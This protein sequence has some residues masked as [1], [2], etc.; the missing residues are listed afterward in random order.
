MIDI[1]LP[2]TSLAAVINGTILLALT[3]R[4]IVLRRRDGVVLGDNGDRVLTK[5]IRGQ[6]NAAEQMPIAII[7]LA[8]AELQGG[9]S[10]VLMILMLM[11]TL[12]RASHAIYFGV[13][14]THWRFRFYG[15]LL[16]LA[17]QAGLILTLLALVIIW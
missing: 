9:Q 6:A 13:H 4:V 3:Y 12:G 2:I 16:T 1:S 10:T 15:M 11:L 17:A 7:L 14:G 5:A 8:L